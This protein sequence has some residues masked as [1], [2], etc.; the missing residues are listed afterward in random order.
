MKLYRKIFTLAILI[1]FNSL[2]HA[3]VNNLSSMVL[4]KLIP[5]LD[6]ENYDAVFDILTD[7]ALPVDQQ[8]YIKRRLAEQHLN[9]LDKFYKINLEVIKPAYFFACSPDGKILATAND[10]K[11]ML[12]D[13]TQSPF[14]CIELLGHTKQIQSIAFS[15]DGK[16]IITGSYDNT[17]RLWDISQN[18]I[19]S[20]QLLG[21]K[22]AVH[23]VALSS[24]EKFALTATTYRVFLWDLETLQI[25]KRIKN[26]HHAVNGLAFTPDSRFA[27][28]G[29]YL[30]SFMYNLEGKKPKEVFANLGEVSCIAVSNDSKFAILGDIYKGNI[31]IIDFTSGD[32]F[33]ILREIKIHDGP[34]YSIAISPDNEHV[35]TGSRDRTAKF[36]NLNDYKLHTISGHRENVID[37]SFSPNGKFALTGAH[38]WSA[39]LWDLSKLDNKKSE[40]I[41]FDDHENIVYQ[42]GFSPDGKYIITAA[43]NS[44]NLYSFEDLNFSVAEL[45]LAIKLSDI[46]E[47]GKPYLDF[48]RDARFQQALDNGKF[49]DIIEE[50]LGDTVENYME[51]NL[52]EIGMTDIEA[53]NAIVK[54][55][56]AVDFGQAI[57]E[58][59]ESLCHI[60]PN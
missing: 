3:P 29:S 33:K 45:I 37:V 49:R 11:L 53:Q 10:E 9:A 56:N 13:L 2:I 19:T 34:I 23:Q 28:I 32:P 51:N 30:R 39:M 36:F 38:D 55:S 59:I 15:K 44:L 12:Y 21:H 22:N 41:V 43:K 60:F 50:Y 27:I 42:S 8:A 40:P 6:T 48:M 20:I 24:N 52:R 46:I 57:A 16:R 58:F 26:Y 31:T 25:V 47:N 1:L 7:S 5:F 35:I 4:D 18:P 17:A 14:A 54:Q